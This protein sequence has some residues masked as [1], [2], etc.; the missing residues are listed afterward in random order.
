MLT[1]THTDM[2]SA[3]MLSTSLQ[4][5]THTAITK[6]PARYRVIEEYEGF[7]IEGRDRVSVYVRLS[8]YKTSLLIGRSLDEINASEQGS[9]SRFPS[10]CGLYGYYRLLDIIARVTMSQWQRPPNPTN[11]WS[12]IKEWSISRTKQALHFRGVYQQWQ[13]LLS[14]VPEPQKSVA[15]AVF[16]ATFDGSQRGCE[17]WP[18][19]YDYPFLVKDILQYRAAAIAA[20]YA[21]SL[22]EQ[23]GL[24]VQVQREHSASA[25][26][27]GA[28]S[29][30]FEAISQ[31]RWG[32]FS[33][34]FSPLDV[35]NGLPSDAEERWKQERLEQRQIVMELLAHD[36]KALYSHNGTAGK[37]LRRSLMSLSG[38]VSGPLLCEFPKLEQFLIRPIVDRVELTTFLLLARSALGW[39]PISSDT[40]EGNILARASRKEILAALHI[41]SN[42]QQREFFRQQYHAGQRMRRQAP[43]LTPWKNGLSLLVGYIYDYCCFCRQT[44]LPAHNGNIVGLVEK[45]ISWHRD[46]QRRTE[47]FQK[48]LLDGTACAALSP[49]PL[50]SN[51]SIAFLST[52]KDIFAEG[53]K[54]GHCIASYASWAVNGQCYLFHVNHQDTEASVQVNTFGQVVQSYGPHNS[55]NAASEYGKHV[56]EKWGSSFARKLIDSDRR[57]I[58]GGYQRFPEDNDPHPF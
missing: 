21:D 55:S 28:P 46:A 52:A 39:G 1:V 14:L 49:V 19:L 2:T 57:P 44:G 20:H 27:S 31:R 26:Q 51:S 12:G 9:L 33:K 25:C 22:I 35:T 43:V 5:T 17:T 38:G 54:M 13:R 8:P 41:L 56:L 3:I 53:E 48:A 40:W 34:E 29:E 11:D 58:Y 15:K 6:Y 36:W 23:V 42:H 47:E 37:S 45:S 50:P 30:R 32:V 24:M 10:A 18:E 7:R 4:G 16:A